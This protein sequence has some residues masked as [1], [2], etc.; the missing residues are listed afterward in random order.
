MSHISPQCITIELSFLYGI[1]LYHNFNTRS[2]A[3][4][5]DNALIIR[6]EWSL[7]LESIDKGGFP[8]CSVI[9]FL[10]K[11][12]DSLRQLQ[13]AWDRDSVCSVGH[14][15]VR[16]NVKKAKYR[17]KYSTDF[18]KEFPFIRAC[19]SAV[20]DH[21]YKYQ[22]TIYNVH[23]SCASGGAYDIR[24]H[25]RSE[26]HAESQKVLS[27]KYFVLKLSWICHRYHF[28]NI[29]HMYH[30]L[31][32]SGQWLW[33]WLKRLKKGKN[34]SSNMEESVLLP[35]SFHEVTYTVHSNRFSCFKKCIL[36]STCSSNQ[37]SINFLWH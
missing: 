27:S 32:T 22:C 26:K 33:H 5:W 10:I 7:Q 30:K 25:S 16:N 24:E 31:N 17:T 37:E 36:F 18:Q 4:I 2:Q 15:L 12:L 3:E 34:L 20:P 14:V 11:F 13:Y 1:T 28:L 23:L 19:S 21:I 29:C 6:V 9:L 8:T 35:P